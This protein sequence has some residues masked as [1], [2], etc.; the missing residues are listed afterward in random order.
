L[1]GQQQTTIEPDDKRYL[2][3]NDRI[4]TAVDRSIQLFSSPIGNKNAGL[5]RPA[6]LFPG[7]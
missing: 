6:F 2:Q 5:E 7:S 3:K 4:T 1:V